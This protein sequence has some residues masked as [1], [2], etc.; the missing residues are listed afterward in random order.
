MRTRVLDVLGGYNVIGV[1]QGHTH[2]NEMVVW[3]GVPYFTSGGGVR[4]LVAWHSAGDA[5]GLYGGVGGEWKMTTRYETFG[6]KSW[7][8][9]IPESMVAFEEGPGLKPLIS[10]GFFRRAKALRLIPKLCA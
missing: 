4:K 10:A 6:F 8:R 3:K 1:L 7:L 5:G 2:I 9:R